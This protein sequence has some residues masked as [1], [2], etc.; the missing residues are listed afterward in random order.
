MVAGATSAGKRNRVRTMVLPRVAPRGHG[1]L[2]ALLAPRADT[3]VHAMP[4][5]GPTRLLALLFALV[6][7]ALP[8]LATI[9]DA[10]QERASG[11]VAVPHAEGERSDSCAAAHRADCAL[12]QLLTTP[13]APARLAA[14]PP[15]TSPHAVGPQGAGPSSRAADLSASARP[16]APPTTA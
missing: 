10:R 6:Q 8:P 7:L 13:A 4:S 14:E 1:G 16:R 9:V 2:R 15:V 11:A 3:I 5:S 12:C